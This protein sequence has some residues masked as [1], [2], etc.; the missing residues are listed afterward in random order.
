VRP[1]KKACLIVLPLLFLAIAASGALAQQPPGPHFRYV[2]MF[3]VSAPPAQYEVVHLILDFAPGAWTPEHFH[4]GDAFV[5]VLEGEVTRREG[6]KED[7]Y[8][9]GETF[10]EA[11]GVHHAAGNEGTAN[12]RVMA[13]ILLSPGA[14]VTVNV[15][16]KPAPAIL[17]TSSFLSRTTFG[18][19]PAE[20]NLTQVVVDFVPGAYIP[21]HVHGG[22]GIATVIQGDI[23]FDTPGGEQRR[24]PGGI[25]IDATAPHDARNVGSGNATVIVTFLIKKGAPVT[26]FVDA[27]GQAAR[28]P[29][30]T[31]VITPPSTGDAGLLLC[32]R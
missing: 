14:P 27:P 13:S 1:T 17:P 5:T 20:F 28:L 16:G 9:P 2:R 12:A 21:W 4:G 22:P 26:T 31:G 3:P 15:P 8:G 18:T 10:R 29:A 24:G 32:A 23:I 6:D 30:S 11:A 25:F 7:A 19:Q